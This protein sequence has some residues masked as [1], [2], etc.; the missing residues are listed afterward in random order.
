MKR[1]LLLTAAIM[2]MTTSAYGQSNEWLVRSS[3]RA[4]A[5]FQCATLAKMTERWEEHLRLFKL[6]YSQMTT[7]LEVVIVTDLEN[8]VI[9]KKG[10][11]WEEI[12]WVIK[13][14]IWAPSADFAA[15]AIWED[16]YTKTSDEII[17]K[18]G[19]VLANINAESAFREKNCKLLE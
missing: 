8:P 1:I 7:L 6:G 15:G 10:I 19:E 9:F 5:A 3:A 16:I 12:P 17:A 2:L 11:P 13:Y 18:H 14:R 4:I